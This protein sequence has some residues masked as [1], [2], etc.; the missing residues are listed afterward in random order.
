MA[1]HFV[2]RSIMINVHYEM[3]VGEGAGGIFGSISSIS[4]QQ[5]KY[6]KIYV[7]Q[8]N[9]LA[10][11]YTLIPVNIFRLAGWGESKFSLFTTTPI[12]DSIFRKSHIS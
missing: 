9:E 6:E 1:A 4:L 11:G 2:D 5:I 7:V 10:E 3:V 12:L 8:S